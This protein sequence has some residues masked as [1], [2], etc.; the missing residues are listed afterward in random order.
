MTKVSRN[1]GRTGRI[2]LLMSCAFVI[3]SGACHSGSKKKLPVST[4]PVADGESIGKIERSAGGTAVVTEV[5][6]L[7]TLS[8]DGAE[9][10]LRTNL[11]T[12][13]GGMDCARMVGQSIAARFLGQPVAVTYTGGAVQIENPTAGTIILPNIKDLTRMN[14]DVTP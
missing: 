13:T 1:A 5:R 6:T 9:L 7:L 14:S 2:A 4:T 11:E 12:L 8:C 3:G 10:T